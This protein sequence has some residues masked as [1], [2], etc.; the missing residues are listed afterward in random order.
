MN[1]NTCSASGRVY[2]GRLQDTTGVNPTARPRSEEPFAMPHPSI[3]AW[4]RR[5]PRA[6]RGLLEEEAARAGRYQ[7]AEGRA[8]EGDAREPPHATA[9]GSADSRVPTNRPSW[10][11]STNSRTGPRPTPRPCALIELLGTRPTRAWEDASD[12]RDQPARAA[13][14]V[15]VAAGP[16]GERAQGEGAGHPPRRTA[17]PDAAVREHTA[18]AVGLLGPIGKPLS[19]DLMKLCTSPDEHVRDRAFDSPA[20]PASAT[21]RASPNS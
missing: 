15:L 10:R 11:R 21:P 20:P 3:R 9:R 1:S 7:R 14:R 18:N 5:A 12:A 4:P 13:V 8:E 19:G 16:K 6:P 2:P 17:R